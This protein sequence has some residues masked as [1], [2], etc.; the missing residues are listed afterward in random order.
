M[1]WDSTKTRQE[2]GYGAEHDRMR[3]QVLAEEPLCRICLAAGRVSAS[4]IADHILCKAEGGGDERENYQGLC[5]SCSDAKTA[6]ESARA[7]GRRAPRR[8]ATVGLD[9][10]PIEAENGGN[11]G[12]FGRSEA[13]SRGSREGG[14]SKV[15]GR[16][17]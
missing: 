8:I 12:L 11:Q 1:A 17:R 14:G 3:K 5:R 7:Q 4:K 10:W 9:G 13:R 15:G 6:A 16:R 2:R